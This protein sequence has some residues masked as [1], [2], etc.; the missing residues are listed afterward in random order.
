MSSKEF[1]I[2]LAA[3]L[4]RHP[5][6]EKPVGWAVV[7]C[8]VIGPLHA[9][10]VAKGPFTRLVA[11][12]D[13][14]AERAENLARQHGAKA[15]TSLEQVLDDPEV[16]AVSICTPSGMHPEMTIRALRAGKH[17]LTEKPMA[18]HLEDADAMIRT[19]EETGGQL[20]VI[21]QRRTQPV[22]R[23]IK[24]A[25][26]EKVLGKPVLGDAYM[27]YYR[28]PEYYRSADWRGTWQWDGGG[29]LM[30][31]GIHIIDMLQWLM[32]PVESVYAHAGTLVREIEVEDTAVAVLKFRN[33]AFG[34]IE[35]TTSVYPGVDHRIELH[36]EKGT[37]RVDGERIVEWRVEGPDG[38]PVSRLEGTT[39]EAGSPSPTSDP[40]AI[41]AD[42]HWIQIQDLALAIRDGRPPLVPGREGRPALEII[43]GI[44]ESSR[45]GREVYL[46]R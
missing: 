28:S 34:V 3:E 15:Y 17:V 11:C 46:G 30:N 10:G 26:E 8:G 45:T 24:A 19:A 7:G 31:Q 41:S 29:A 23:T 36:G 43:L 14:V 4:L 6:V 5:P 38:K 32:G 21:F 1:T 16:E 20:A 35:G 37:I 44:Y 18:I 42:G 39:G 12:C 2:N 33:G 25:M 9:A 13:I 40:R 22:F 27:K